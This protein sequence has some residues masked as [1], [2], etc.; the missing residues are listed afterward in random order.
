MKKIQLTKGKVALVDDE[1]YQYL[2]QFKWQAL[3]GRHT[4]YAVRQEW[5]SGK[6]RSKCIYMHREILGLNNPKDHCDHGDGDGLNNQ[7]FNI[8]KCSNNQNRFN[9][10]HRDVGTSKFRG[11]CFDKRVKKWRSRVNKDKKAHEL[12]FFNTQEDAAK[13]YNFKAIE[14][15]GEFANLNIL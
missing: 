6:N 9:M 1:D 15:F 4:Y 13:A 3:K 7:R 14:L 2:S 12:G 11:V 10:R 8:R 5:I